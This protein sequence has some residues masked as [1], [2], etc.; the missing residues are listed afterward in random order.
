MASQGSAGSARVDGA[1]GLPEGSIA[2]NTTNTS[3]RD[4]GTLPSPEE[5]RA[6]RRSAEYRLDP[7][8]DLAFDGEPMEL[9]DPRLGW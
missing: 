2:S 6:A 3:A 1:A 8:P 7:K 5:A 9:L 4:L